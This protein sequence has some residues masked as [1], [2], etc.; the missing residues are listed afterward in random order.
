MKNKLYTLL[1]DNSG[2]PNYVFSKSRRQGQS[3][4]ATWGDLS[5]VYCIDSEKTY[6]CIV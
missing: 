2:L 6:Q 4:H 1:I 3:P 5:F